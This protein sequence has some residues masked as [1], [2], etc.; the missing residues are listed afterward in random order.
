MIT[1]RIKDV[2]KVVTQLEI[3]LTIDATAEARALLPTTHRTYERTMRI[4]AASAVL[5]AVAT[6]G[7]ANAAPGWNLA[8]HYAETEASPSMKDNLNLYLMGVSGALAA[9][10]SE[11]VAKKQPPLFCVPVGRTLTPDI[12]QRVF[13]RE[14]KAQ[15]AS[16]P[17]FEL[18]NMPDESI[19]LYGLEH[20]LPCS[21]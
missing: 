16:T 4:K 18:N 8:G 12:L 11:L 21:K 7:Q 13:E 15:Q 9:A 20:A 1:I 19:L 5:L 6:L 14:L 3:C 10:N 2:N 17:E